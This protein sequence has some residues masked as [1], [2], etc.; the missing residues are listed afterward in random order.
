MFAAA[1]R[2][3]GVPAFFQR[4]TFELGIGGGTSAIEGAGTVG[5]MAARVGLMR[6]L[7]DHWGAGAAMSGA[8]REGARSDSSHVDTFLIDYTVGVRW[9]PFGTDRGP[10]V[11]H[12]RAGAGW[13][14][15]ENE[16]TIEPTRRVETKDHGLGLCVGAGYALRFGTEVS[17]GVET[18]MHWLR[19]LENPA[20]F[21]ASNIV[22]EWH[23]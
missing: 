23:L 18:E 6:L 5:G 16:E 17:L 19:R 21:L 11:L 20:R 4:W 8:L 22:V 15:A 9:L 3:D 13:A 14:Y 12:V 10:G 2:A 1:A 7:G